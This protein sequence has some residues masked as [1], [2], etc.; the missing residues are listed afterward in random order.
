MTRRC[1]STIAVALASLA[2]IAASAQPARA[3]D[4][5]RADPV[6]RQ[7]F[8]QGRAALLDGRFPEAR[9][10]LRASFARQPRQATAFNLV[11]ALLGT[12][13][14]VEASTLCARI[15]GGELGPIPD[16]RRAQ[17]ESE[18][19][20]ATRQV[21]V[22]RVRVEP[23]DPPAAIRVDGQPAPD[24][25]AGGERRVTVDP[26]AHVVVAQSARG[27]AERSVRVGRGE[28]PELL[29]E[30]VPQP[31]PGR[32]SEPESDTTWVWWAGAGAVALAA[33]VVAIVLVATS[34]DEEWTVLDEPIR[35]PVFGA[36]EVL[37][38]GSR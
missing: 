32:E 20:R 17:I 14:P 33:G 25:P 9:D 15:L 5:G 3:Q 13:E 26:G 22:L 24:G 7:Q 2:S 38:A 31:R 35:D 27:R 36:T 1:C 4:R 6:A 29:L 12:E 28:S 10:A 34:G 11:L 8:E 19:G 21:A 16:A 37:R 18:C 30:L 23:D